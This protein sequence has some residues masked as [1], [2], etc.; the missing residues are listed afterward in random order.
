MQTLPPLRE[1]QAFEAAARLLSYRKAA[2][3]L[4]VTPTAVSHQI[5]LLEEYCGRT[6]F[7]RRPRPISLTQ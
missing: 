2:E 5:R 6:L 7:I 4:T 1:L 3:E